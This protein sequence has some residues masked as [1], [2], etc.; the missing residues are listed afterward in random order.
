M[1][2]EVE[3]REDKLINNLVLL[4]E[5]FVKSTHLFLSTE[6]IDNIKKY[7]PNALNMVSHLIALY[8]ND[9][10]VG[11]MGIEGNKLEMLFI[12]STDLKRGYGSKLLEYGIKKYKVNCLTV[13][14]QNPNAISFYERF[15]FVTYKRSK[16]DEQGNSYPILYMKC[17][18]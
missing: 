6:E 14:E 9:E 18:R 2:I 3:N 17:K 12:K 4:W 7:V 10:I 1:I 16:L 8:E 15:G 11:F 13:N 5:N